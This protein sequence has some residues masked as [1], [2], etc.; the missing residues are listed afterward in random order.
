MNIDIIGFPLNFPGS[1]FYGI[2]KP[3]EIDF[4]RLEA[5]H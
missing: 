4:I 2:D 1:N 5:Y 3:V